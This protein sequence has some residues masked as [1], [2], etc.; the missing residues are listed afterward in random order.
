VDLGLAAPI[1]TAVFDGSARFVGL[2]VGTDPEMTPRQVLGSVPYAY[3][4]G[5]VTGD[6]HPRT[7]VI[8]GQT[9]IDAT[10]AWTGSPAGL[11][12]PTGPQGPA[13]GPTGP[14]GPPGAMGQPGQLGATGAQGAMGLQ[15]PPGAQGPA[16]APGQLGPIGPQGAIGPSGATGATGPIGPS[17]GPI[18]PQGPMGATGAQGPAGA[19]GPGGLQGPTGAQGVAGAQGATGALGPQG[20]TGAQGVAGAQGPQGPQGIAGLQGPVGA[21]GAQG[22][23]GPQGAT[24]SQGPQGAIGPQGPTGAQGAPWQPQAVTTALFGASPVVHYTGAKFVV[25]ATDASTVQV[26]TTAASS[27]I[28]DISIE[29]PSSCALTSGSMSFAARSSNTVGD[30]LV[31]TLCAEGSP[32]WVTVFDYATRRNTLLRCWKLTTNGNACQVLF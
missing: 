24:G 21:T 26:R 12:G 2:A 23:T 8:N 7:V 27:S 5:D 17:G 11:Q 14:M 4:A 6:I 29:Y 32:I 10:G 13:G 28:L 31:G 25:E 30:T 9:V 1:P 15:G 16:G 20:P 18:G 22:A 3:L 19:Q